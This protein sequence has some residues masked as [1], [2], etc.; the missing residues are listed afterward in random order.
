MLLIGVIAIQLNCYKLVYKMS[1]IIYLN[2]DNVSA[3]D[4]GAAMLF[5]AINEENF[6]GRMAKYTFLQSEIDNNH[7]NNYQLIFTNVYKNVRVTFE[8]SVNKQHI[9]KN[10]K[11][12]ELEFINRFIKTEIFNDDN[13]LLL[14]NIENYK[15]YGEL[16]FVLNKT[17]LLI[18][19][20]L[21]LYH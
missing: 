8:Y 5:C 4:R 13:E 19:S 16:K 7:N 11:T 20:N 14:E 21:K 2:T 12:L 1:D 10:G 15:T 3:D 18:E 6:N 9:I 17:I